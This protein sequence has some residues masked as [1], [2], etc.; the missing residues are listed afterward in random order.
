[1]TKRLKNRETISFSKSLLVALL[2]IVPVGS[3]ASDNAL[4]FSAGF[5]SIKG[6]NARAKT[7]SSI[8]GPGAYQLAYRR[9]VS[10]HFD[11]GL[12]YS[13]YFSQVITGDSVFGLD[14]MAQ[15]YPFSSSRGVRSESPE[16][17][18][19]IT[20]VWR[21]YVGLAF[22]QRNFQGV[23]ATYVG[24]AGVIGTQYALQGATSLFAYAR[25]AALNAS[26]SSTATELNVSLGVSFGF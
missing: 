2:G 22:M 20:E 26:S 5:Y 23:Q 18:V 3:F 8:S 4:D 13:V 16:V 15:Y 1:M 19:T 6:T 21:P 14:L 25:Y 24:F 12:G 17:M 7:S 9:R 10:P 11:V